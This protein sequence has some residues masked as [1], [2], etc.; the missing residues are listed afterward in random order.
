MNK[1]TELGRKVASNQ[2]SASRAFNSCSG[3]EVENSLCGI[4]ETID[5]VHK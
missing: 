2:G 5:R 1:T 4:L 3:P